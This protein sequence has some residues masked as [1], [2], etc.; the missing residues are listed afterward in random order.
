M[1]GTRY[2]RAIVVAALLIGLVAAGGTP[3]GAAADADRGVAVDRGNEPARLAA[4]APTAEN[5]SANATPFADAGIDPAAIEEYRNATEAFAN[6]TAELNAT[7]D[8]VA[9]GSATLDEANETLANLSE[10]YETMR[11]EET[12]LLTRLTA[13]AKEGNATGTFDAIETLADDRRDRRASLEAATESYVTTV[14][15]ERAE[16]RS[17]VQLALAGSLVGGLLV[18]AVGGAAVP[19]LAA[20]RVEEKLK[21]SRN[22]TYD[23]KAALLPILVGLLLVAAGIGVLVGTGLLGDLVEVIR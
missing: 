17:T 11:A 21:L 12:R 5:G 16:P 3:I 23:R 20:R 9:N 6:A 13:D 10:Q 19:L 2:R 15:A 7:T 4:T 1:S 18:G 22:V 8:A 14:E